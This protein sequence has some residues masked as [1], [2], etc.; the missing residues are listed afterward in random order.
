MYYYPTTSIPLRSHTPRGEIKCL[1]LSQF[2]SITMSQPDLNRLR[3]QLAGLQRS[4]NAGRARERAFFNRRASGA[5]APQRKF[6]RAKKGEG[7]VGGVL[8]SG[9]QGP[10]RKKWDVNV[11][12]TNVFGTTPYITS[13]LN[14]IAPGTGSTNRIGDRVKVKGVDLEFNIAVVNTN[15]P[16]YADFFLVWDKAPDATITT[17]AVIFASSATNLTF[18]NIDNLE[19]FQVLKRQSVNLD[20]AMAQSAII[21]WH[22]AADFTSR[23][24]A[25]TGWPSTNDLL[26]VVLCPGVS[27]NTGSINMAFVARTSFTDE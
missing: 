14:N 7:V 19:R 18:G 20:A 4:E 23:F 24:P 6:R 13:L 8:V 2:N 16:V 5:P 17:P 10:E 22:L 27:G 9:P 26:V 1:K 21:K 11:A 3:R 25:A 12:S 15:A